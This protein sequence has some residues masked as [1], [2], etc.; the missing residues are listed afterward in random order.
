MGHTDG[1]WPEAGSA[2]LKNLSSQTIGPEAGYGW[3]ANPGGSGTRAA[4]V[5]QQYQS[6]TGQAI[7]PAPRPDLGL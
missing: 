7:E 4:E 1:I 5:I 2:Q 6:G 3:G